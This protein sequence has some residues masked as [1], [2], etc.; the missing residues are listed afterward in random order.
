MK[1]FG[2][3]RPVRD[4]HGE[5]SGLIDCPAR[6]RTR[7]VCGALFGTDKDRRLIVSLEA[8][9]LVC[10]RPERTTRVYR[11]AAKD[12]F[13]WLLRSEA[14]RVNLERARDRK[15]KKA[16]RLAR[17]RQERAEKRLFKEGQ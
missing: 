8:G 4:K 6:A 17:Q 7:D 10:V 13:H 3:Q 11:V 14:N 1:T 9:D 12:L 2:H 16:E 15:A 5:I